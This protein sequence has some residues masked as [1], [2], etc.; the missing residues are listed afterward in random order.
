VERDCCPMCHSSHSLYIGLSYD[1]VRF[2]DTEN[3]TNDMV[4]V[5]SV[6]LVWWHCKVACFHPHSYSRSLW[7][8]RCCY[9]AKGTCSSENRGVFLPH[10]ISDPMSY[11]PQCLES[12]HCGSRRWLQVLPDVLYSCYWS[13]SIG[14]SAFSIPTSQP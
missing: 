9:L 11:C 3:G 6:V 1:T 14:I 7:T 12:T 13:D 4:R 2:T 8:G 10:H 5:V